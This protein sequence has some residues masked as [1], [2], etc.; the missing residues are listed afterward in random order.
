MEWMGTL[1]PVSWHFIS[2][3]EIVRQISMKLG[4]LFKTPLQMSMAWG[5]RVQTPPAPSS[6]NNGQSPQMNN[7]DSMQPTQKKLPWGDSPSRLTVVDPRGSIGR[8]GE[9]G[10]IVPRTG[11]HASIEVVQGNVDQLRGTLFHG[12][13]ELAP[14]KMPHSLYSAT[15]FVFWSKLCGDAN[16]CFVLWSSVMAPPQANPSGYVDHDHNPQNWIHL[17]QNASNSEGYSHGLTWLKDSVE[18][19]TLHSIV[20][21]WPNVTIWSRTS[22]S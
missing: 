5:G 13:S 18:T 12:L 17:H 9:G 2:S 20:I 14:L 8:R 16:N 4:K 10:G 11:E 22:L 1:S 6:L 3:S 7:V 21:T 19:S 15:A